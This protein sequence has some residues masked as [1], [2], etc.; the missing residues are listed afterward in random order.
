MRRVAALRDIVVALNG[1]TDLGPTLDSAAELQ[2]RVIGA[3]DP[4]WRYDNPRW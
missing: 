4:T 2:M 1:G 3:G